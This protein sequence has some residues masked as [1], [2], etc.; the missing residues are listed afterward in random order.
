[1]SRHRARLYHREHTL[2]PREID[3]TIQEGAASELARLSDA[4]AQLD[5]P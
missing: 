3:A 4:G 1:M 5:Q 2:S